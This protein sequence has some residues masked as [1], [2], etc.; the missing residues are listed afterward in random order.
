MLGILEGI[1]GLVGDS[2]ST[3]EL[4][5]RSFARAASSG[6]SSFFATGG[7]TAAAAEADS[8][9]LAPSGGGLYGSACR[10]E[11]EA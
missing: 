11:L 2:T 6:S 7:G 9:N 5:F 3:A 8:G 10:G 4:G 1:P